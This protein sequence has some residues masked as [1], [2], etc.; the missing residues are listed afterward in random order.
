LNR[1]AAD[2]EAPSADT[3]MKRQLREEKLLET[4][5]K[6]RQRIDERFPGSGLSGVAAEVEQIT[7]EALVRAEVISRPNLW[8]RAGL[9]LLALI[10]VGGM[11]GY[12]QSQS[13]QRTIGQAV[14]GFLDDAKGSA[15]IL[16]AAAIFLFT[17]ETRLKRRRALRAVH[18]LRAVAHIIDMHQLTKD[19]DRL[20]DP[21]AP[22]EV[23]GRPLNAEGLGRYLHYCTELLAVISKISQLYIQEFPDAV[24]VA[25]VDNF[26]E[27]ATG[28]SN[29]IWQKLM[30][31]DRI[32]ADV[33]PLPLSD[34]PPPQT[35]GPTPP[36]TASP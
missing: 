28:L 18:E 9:I 24:A 6:V 27:L 29:K 31:L 16:T 19:P 30:I 10:A 14:L 13:G 7:K 26:E 5:T 3:P 11:F 1:P 21:N 15:A 34:S 25:T 20:G 4:I 32:R 35:P 12:I 8:L 23:A 33:T 17:L 22:V 2:P 36:Q